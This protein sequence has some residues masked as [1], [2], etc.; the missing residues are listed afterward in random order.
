MLLAVLM[1]SSRS[2]CCEK[3]QILLLAVGVLILSPRLYGMAL[4]LVLVDKLSLKYA[5][6]RGSRNEKSP[7]ATARYILIRSTMC[8]VDQ[9]GVDIQVVGN[10]HSASYLCSHVHVVYI[11]SVAKIL[12]S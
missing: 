2:R 11:Q 10:S 8:T 4:A 9:Y 12:Y 3:P 6:C 7:V 5:A 1:L